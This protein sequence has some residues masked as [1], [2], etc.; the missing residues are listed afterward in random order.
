MY[1]HLLSYILNQKGDQQA[2][3]KTAQKKNLDYEHMKAK[4]PRILAEM[5]QMII[6]WRKMGLH[7]PRGV[8]NIFEFTWE[9]LMVCPPRKSFSGLYCPIVKLLSCEEADRS[10]TATSRAQKGSPA[11]SAP[12]PNY[13]SPSFENQQ[14]L[15]KFQKRSVHLLTELLKMKMK[16]M[17]DAVAGEFSY[18]Q[19]GFTSKICLYGVLELRKDKLSNTL[20]AGMLRSKTDGGSSSQEKVSTYNE[21]FDPCPE[22]R[23]RLRG[24]CRSIYPSGSIAVC[25]FPICCVAK[26]ITLLFQDTP[27]QTLLVFM[28]PLMCHNGAGSACP[29]FLWHIQCG[30]TVRDKDGHL[31]HHWSW[32]SKTQI[33]QSLDFQVSNRSIPSYLCDKLFSLLATW[34][35]LFFSSFHFPQLS[36]R[37]I[38]NDVKEGQWCR[39]LIEIRRRFEKSVK[40]FINAVLL[41]SEFADISNQSSSFLV[42]LLPS[43]Q[44]TPYASHRAKKETP[45]PEDAHLGLD[46]WAASPADCPIVLHRILTKEDEGLCCKCVVKIPLITDLE[47]EKF[48][49]APRNP[50][51]VIVICVLSPENHS[52]SPFFEWSIEKLYMQMQ[53]GRPSPCV[54]CKHDAFRFLRYDLESPLNQTPPL[55]VQKHGVVP[56]MVVMYAGGKLLFGSCVFN[57]Y[58]YSKRD[59]LKQINQVCLD[60]KMG[61][62][63]PQ[64]FKFRRTMHP[65]VHCHFICYFC[66]ASNWKYNIG[67][68][69]LFLFKA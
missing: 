2:D 37:N 19:G 62:F 51:Q 6:T 63:L 55:L 15:L 16:I 48:I 29:Y 22:A 56:G 18:L 68:G 17:I 14:M 3:K 25:Q 60:C 32:Y 64:S 36:V 49:N 35:I 4:A 7:V 38:E 30:G 47:F 34:L 43:L 44:T 33:L 40:Q 5:V 41:V 1:V 21:V 66:Q 46:T 50:H 20:F 13:M 69:V 28:V 9:E 27:N 10:S 42:F 45:S 67:F 58:S 12:K 24:I 53:H 52:Y 57:G 61:H 31:V 59:L 26:T 54:Q 11:A 39:S 8:K 65:A 23:E